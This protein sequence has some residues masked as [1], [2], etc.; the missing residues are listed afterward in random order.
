[1]NNEFVQNALMTISFMV[2]G[3]IFAYAL[4]GWG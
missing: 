4:I 3:A 1:M 2:A